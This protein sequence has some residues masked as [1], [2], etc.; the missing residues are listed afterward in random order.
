MTLGLKRFS[1]AA[2]LCLAVTLSWSE[3]AEAICPIQPASSPKQ[4]AVASYID[5]CEPGGEEPPPP[6]PPTQANNMRVGAFCYL[7]GPQADDRCTVSYNVWDNPAN[8]II[9]IWSD[10]ALISCEGRTYWGG[11]IDWI[12]ADGATVEFRHHTNWPTLDPA[13]PNAEL[14][15]S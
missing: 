4:M 2:L 12:G 14:V 3:R 6:P 15:R 9:C 5:P 10:N 11:G 8:N 7:P 1:A 13:W